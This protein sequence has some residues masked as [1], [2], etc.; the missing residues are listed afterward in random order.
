MKIKRLAAATGF[1][2]G[3]VTC[4]D[5]DDDGIPMPAI[6]WSTWAAPVSMIRL[7]VM[8]CSVGD[9]KVYRRNSGFPV[10]NDTGTLEKTWSLILD[11]GS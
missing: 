8:I 7:P 4:N 9:V 3:A 11:V 6:T 5:G 10:C 2:D 1:N